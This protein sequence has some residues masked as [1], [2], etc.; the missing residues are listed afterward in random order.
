MLFSQIPFIC[1]SE[2]LIPGVRDA[3]TTLRLALF[4][5]EDSKLKAQGH[6]SLQSEFAPSLG[7]MRYFLKYKTETKYN[8]NNKDHFI[9]Y[10]IK[11]TVH[12]QKISIF[13]SRRRKTNMWIRR[14]SLEWEQNTYGRSYRDKG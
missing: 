3:G 13:K 1:M 10:F 2:H 8:K 6:P 4:S 11:D 7:Y 14:S 12:C 5:R 9:L